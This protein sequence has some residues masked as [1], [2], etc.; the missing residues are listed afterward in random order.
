MEL[1]IFVILIS[2]CGFINCA[3]RCG[4]IYANNVTQADAQII[5]DKHNELR[6]LI[7][8]GKVPGQP[9]GINL[10][11]MKYDQN[12]AIEAQKI[13]NTCIFAHKTVKDGR[14]HAVG[15]NLYIQYSTAASKEVNWRAAIQSWFDEYKDYKYG[16]CC[17]SGSKMTGHYTQVVWAETEYVGCGYTYFNTNEAFMYQ[18]LYVCNYGPAG[19][20]VGRVPYQTGKSGCENLC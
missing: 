10:K 18:K 14:W 1:G 7:A 6:Q 15:Q 2:F 11:R 20:Y 16:K 13:A 4:K 19:N 8:N 3:S 5:V 9:R 12:L 17:S